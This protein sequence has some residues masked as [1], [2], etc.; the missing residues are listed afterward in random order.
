MDR[1]ES[2][3]F[4]RC[5]LPHLDAGYRLARWLTRNDQDAEDAVQE[6]S[7]RALKYFRTFDGRD[8]RS[9]FLR[10]VRNICNSAYARNRAA[11]EP[12]DE[13]RHATSQSA[14]DPEALAARTD[15]AAFITRILNRLP[16]RFRTVLVLREI[17]ELSYRE[18][19]DVIGTP[20]GTVMSRLSRARRAFR[21]AALGEL[22][23]TGE[24]PPQHGRTLSVLR[25]AAALS[26]I[27]GAARSRS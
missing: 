14:G 22:G 8:A 21:D 10:I 9:W 11:H 27:G 23:R 25:D 17:E 2:E 26:G 3:T 1:A 5:I 6:A 16:E 12:F 4:E 19:A 24:Q 15:E 13:E 18:L 7:L 20:V